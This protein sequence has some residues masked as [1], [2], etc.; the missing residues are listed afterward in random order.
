[1]PT[2]HAILANDVKGGDFLGPTGMLEL[3]G[4]PGVA[5][6]SEYSK[7]IGVAEKLW[8][9]SEQLSGIKFIL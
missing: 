2:L 5:K 4:K 9:L 3:K 1:M 8:D 6:R 7:D